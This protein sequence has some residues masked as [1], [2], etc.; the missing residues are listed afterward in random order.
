MLAIMHTL[1]PDLLASGKVEFTIA[2]GGQ[3]KS[4]SLTGR[5]QFDSVNVAMDGVLNGLSSLN[6]TLVF[7]EGR[8]DVKQLTA[9]TGGGQLKIGG[10]D[11]VLAASI[12]HFGE[13]TIGEAK[14]AMAAAGIPIR[15]IAREHV[16]A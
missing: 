3:V 13:I 6:G 1:D 10:A 14:A 4:P 11:A 9:M 2:A 15:P 7:N 16:G 8:L 5:V 12:F